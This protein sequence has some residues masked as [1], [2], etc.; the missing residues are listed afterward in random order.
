MKVAAIISV[1]VVFIVSSGHCEMQVAFSEH[2]VDAKTLPDFLNVKAI[3]KRQVYG[4]CTRTELAEKISSSFPQDCTSEIQNTTDAIINQSLTTGLN[5]TAA[6]GQV[7]DR[8]AAI[9]EI[10]CRPRCGNPFVTS[11]IQCGLPEVSDFW[12]GLCTKNSNDVLCYEILGNILVG[13]ILVQIHCNGSRD[14]TGCPANCRSALR[15][16]GRYSGC[17]LNVLNT[18]YSRSALETVNMLYGL[19]VTSSIQYDLWSW[20]GV[21][22]PGYCNLERSTLQ[23]ISTTA[24]TTQSSAETLNLTTAATTQSSAETLNLTKVLILLTSV[25]IIVLL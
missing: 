13:E 8:I 15:N 23:A 17:C 21:A 9:S 7:S 1:A 20:C 5:G 22:T 12:R 16:I 11:Y 25:V 19:N 10:Y 6:L 18:T 24:A 2:D 3:E 4:T 14:R